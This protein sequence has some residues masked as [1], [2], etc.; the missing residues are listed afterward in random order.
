M[1]KPIIILL[2]MLLKARYTPAPGWDVEYGQGAIER[3][4]L[5]HREVQT[6]VWLIAVEEGDSA[7]WERRLNE[8]AKHG[9]FAV[10]CPSPD[11]EQAVRDG[12]I[13]LQ[14]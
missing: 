10:E 8:T 9:S 6:N 3:N 4:D 1:R 13:E 2:L 7:D 14:R 12:R 11:E 5:R